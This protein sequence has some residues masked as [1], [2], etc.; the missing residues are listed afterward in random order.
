M[1]RILVAGLNPAW[2]TVLGFDAFM[3]GEVNR[4][5][6][7][8][9]LASGKGLNAAKVLG[10]L[11]HE[12]WLLQILGGANG[13]RCL[14]GCESLGI[15]SVAAWVD[16]ET[17]QCL[18]L[19][20]KRTGTA[21]EIIEPFR[22]DKPGLD[23]ELM[24]ELPSDPLAFDAIA[25]CGSIPSGVSGDIYIDL[26]SRYRPG[27]SVVDAW[28][29]LDP[30]SLAKATCVKVNAGELAALR[31]ETGT[32]D[33]GLGGPL[34]AVTAGAGEAYMLRQG[35]VLAR[36]VPPRL[37]ASVNP[38]GAGD[39]VTAGLVHFLA[40]GLDAPEA[41]RRALAIGSASCLDPMPAQ[42]SESD[43]QRLLPLVEMRN[44]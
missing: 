33:K 28:Q 16:E 38:I 21:T 5:G 44:G 40:A 39:A 10:R 37:S 31:R 9:N 35:K 13:R 6:S 43:F 30:Q 15:R 41:F 8:A 14:E 23:S 25:L 1:A 34:F 12:V 24:A 19:L 22:V 26:L 32:D 20:D 36:F 7:I 11:G 42:Y 18:T 4:A 2:Q 27:V 3:P 29:G 17:R